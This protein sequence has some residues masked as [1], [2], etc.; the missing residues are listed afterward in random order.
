MKVYD[1]LIRIDNK[2]FRQLNVNYRNFLNN[3]D[4]VLILNAINYYNFVNLVVF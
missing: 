2:S 1:I 3:N 4:V